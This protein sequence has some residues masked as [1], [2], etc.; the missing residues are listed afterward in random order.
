MP[1]TLRHRL[2]VEDVGVIVVSTMLK[3]LLVL[4]VLGVVGYDSITMSINSLSLKDDAQAA[5]QE[6]HQVMHDRR[7]PQA[8]YNAVVRFAT[9]RGL[10]VI[11]QSFSVGANNT[12]TVELRREAPVIMARYVPR[13]NSYVVATATGTASDQVP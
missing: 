5:A 4:G 10:T 1:T 2:R 3:L 13:V 11:P 6:G 7:D 9:E 12:V 8:A